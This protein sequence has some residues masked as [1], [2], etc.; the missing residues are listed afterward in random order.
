MQTCM[1]ATRKHAGTHTRSY[2]HILIHT[3]SHTQ[4]F[5]YTCTQPYANLQAMQCVH[6]HAD[7]QEARCT[8]E[9]IAHRQAAIYTQICTQPYVRNSHIYA[10]VLEHIYEAIQTHARSNART[11]MRQWHT[12]MCTYLYTNTCTKPSTQICTQ[13]Y[14]RI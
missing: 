7:M 13:P 5:N 8:R 10:H 4:T 6:I 14:V 9:Y 1:L 12:F 3:R 11:F 2:A